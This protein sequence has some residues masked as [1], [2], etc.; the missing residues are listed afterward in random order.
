MTSE[1]EAHLNRKLVH[2]D[3]KLHIWRRDVVNGQASLSQNTDK[4][5]VMSQPGMMNIMPGFFYDELN[6]GLPLAHRLSAVQYRTKAAPKT[7]VHIL[8]KLLD[9][10]SRSHDLDMRYQVMPLIARHEEVAVALAPKL[11]EIVVD[12]KQPERVR[13][14]AL[15]PLYVKPSLET[16]ETFLTLLK[17]DAIG[18][19]LMV[20]NNLI[21][22]LGSGPAMR[23]DRWLTRQLE[24]AL[25][26]MYRDRSLPADLRHII[27]FT[28]VRV[29]ADPAALFMPVI[30]DKTEAREVVFSS[31][32][33]LLQCPASKFQGVFS[34]L[35]TI[36][37]R[38]G[39]D[40]GRNLRKRISE[41]EDRINREPSAGEPVETRTSAEPRASKPPLQV[42]VKRIG[43]RNR[44]VGTAPGCY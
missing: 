38:E 41:A 30:Q 34:E 4:S 37:N 15:H 32:S 10:K 16:V 13:S 20:Q 21:W 40:L 22:N 44:R 42:T 3:T 5:K 33:A 12:E 26:G 2:P 27:P 25:I 23:G 35:D 28:L 11:R 17:Q 9:S 39:G 7:A 29:V 43:G 1:V 19:N 14:Y 6:T 24:P 18:D 8:W 31:I 36:A